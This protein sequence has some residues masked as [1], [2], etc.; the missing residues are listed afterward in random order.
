MAQLYWSG[1][2][3][4][5]KCVKVGG[6]TMPCSTVIGVMEN[7]RR[8]SLIEGTSLQ[9]L[10]PLERSPGRERDRVMFVRVKGDPDQML[11][12]VRR[13]LQSAA[14]DLPY[15]DVR[16]M[17]SLLDAELKPW[18]LG[19]TMFSVFGLVGL[20]LAV[21][22]LYATLAYDVAQRSRELSVRVA[23]GAESRQIVRLVMRGGV[24]LVV[25]GVLLGWLVALASGR[26]VAE[27]L[28]EVSPRDVAIFGGVGA[29]LVIV[30]VLATALPAWRATQVDLREAM[31]AE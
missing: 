24:G 18:T 12:S 19:S 21:V 6:D 7:A 26:W 25:G 16:P 29:V 13:A 17:H 2:D 11:E 30:G 22:G 14:P 1:A 31:A 4:V 5:G 3:P 28:Y 20:A 8:Q 27:L 15:A 10:V 9:Y 23:L